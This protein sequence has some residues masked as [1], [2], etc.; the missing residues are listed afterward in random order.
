MHVGLT[1]SAWMCSN[2]FLLD[3][4][5]VCAVGTRMF[6]VYQYPPQTELLQHLCLS[7]VLILIAWGCTHIIWNRLKTV[8][9]RWKNKN[10]NSLGTK[11]HQLKYPASETASIFKK[12]FTDK[13]SNWKLLCC[14]VGGGTE[15][16]NLPRFASLN[17]SN[18]F[19]MFWL[20]I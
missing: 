8:F 20:D 13:F 9:E 17:N 16:T 4:M 19:P 5:I 1:L 2:V 7:S 3:A 11:W 10:F 12:Y 18:L 14:V 6:I 15:H